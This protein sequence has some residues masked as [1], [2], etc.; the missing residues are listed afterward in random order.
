MKKT[1]VNCKSHCESM[2]YIE[3]SNESSAV[4]VIILF[5]SVYMCL[6]VCGSVSSQVGG[7]PLP[8]PN[9]S[10]SLHQQHQA[11]LHQQSSSP[12]ALGSST[13]GPTLGPL[14]YGW[15]QG[16]TA[17]GEIYFINHNDQTTSWND[18]RLT[19]ALFHLPFYICLSFSDLCD[20]YNT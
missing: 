1:I 18:P 4:F 6:C 3:H 8:H 5:L 16:V 13:L 10:L 19:S 2:Y 7:Y 15:E 9:L 11:Q 14:P 17:A 12:S 20:T